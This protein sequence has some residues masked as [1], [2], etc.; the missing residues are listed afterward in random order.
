MTLQSFSR[1]S[2]FELIS[3]YDIQS[4]HMR[5]VIMHTIQ[6]LERYDDAADEEVSRLSIEIAMRKCYEFLPR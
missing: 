1:L 4:S 2:E 5:E 6:S 3:L